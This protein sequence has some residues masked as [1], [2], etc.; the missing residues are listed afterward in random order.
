MSAYATDY[1]GVICTQLKELVD[2]T[3]V[4]INNED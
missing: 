3:N 1:F 2:M 4:F